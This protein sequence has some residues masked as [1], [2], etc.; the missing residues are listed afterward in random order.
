MFT[1]RLTSK[2]DPYSASIFLHNVFQVECT[3]NTR[4]QLCWFVRRNGCESRLFP[5]RDYYLDAEE[6]A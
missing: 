1:V 5:V 6:E 4:N 3:Y 2:T